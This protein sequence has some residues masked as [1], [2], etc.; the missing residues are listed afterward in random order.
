MRTAEMAA[1]RFSDLQEDDPTDRGPSRPRLSTWQTA[2]LVAAGGGVGAALRLIVTLSMPAVTTPTLVEVPW[3]TLWVNLIGCLGLGALVGALEIRPGRPWMRPLLGTGLCGGFTTMS[4]VVLEGSAM[5]GAEFPIPA[6]GYAVATV[7][8]CLGA[9]LTGF[10]LGRRLARRRED[11]A[12]R[13]EDSA[14][15]RAERPGTASAQP[16]RGSAATGGAHGT[17]HAAEAVEASGSHGVDGV[18][19]GHEPPEGHEHVEGPEDLEA[20]DSPDDRSDPE[21]SEETR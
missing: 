10:V 2:L 6:L 21:Q 7:V 3:A 14:G 13:R 19:E 15:R 11:S 1:L 17:V 16:A 12:G 5:I 9:V 8:L 18:P 4:S 20:P